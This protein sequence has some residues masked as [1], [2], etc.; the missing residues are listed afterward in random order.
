MLSKKG[1][2]SNLGRK[3]VYYLVV[4]FALVILFFYVNGMFVN[5]E[6]AI[7]VD[8]N[9]AQHLAYINVLVN[10]ISYENNGRVY[11]GLID[12]NKYNSDILG[13]CV[14]VP[15]KLQLDAKIIESGEFISGDKLYNYIRYVKINGKENE[16][17]SQLIITF[18]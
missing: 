4:L 13:K 7:L 3:S 17:F 5:Y 10:C 16:D 12:E 18:N 11:F 2:E 14:D 1:D 6:K 15:V 9:E 8:F